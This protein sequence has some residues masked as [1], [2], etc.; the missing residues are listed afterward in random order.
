MKLD[1]NV[2]LMIGS[3]LCAIGGFGL[4]IVSGRIAQE[5]QKMLI[6]DTCSKQLDQKMKERGI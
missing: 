2:I 6:E 3:A 1:K 4:N 5:Q